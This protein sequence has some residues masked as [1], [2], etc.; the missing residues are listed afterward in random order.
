MPRK[1]VVL[2]ILIVMMFTIIACSN[3]KVAESNSKPRVIITSDGEIDDECSMVRCMLYANEWD[4]EAI[5][6]SSSQYHWHGHR[7]AGDDWIE[8]YLDAYEQVYHNLIKHDKDYPSPD[9]LR[10]RTALGN[11]KTE[12]EMDEITAGSELIVKVLLDDTDKRPIWLQAWGGPNTIARAL[13]T[14]EEEHPERMAEVANKIR[15]FMIWEQDS[16][17]QSYIRKNWGKYNIQ[18]IV[19]DQFEAIAYRWKR[20]QP[21]EMHPWYE[22]VWMTE[23]ILQNHGPLCSLYE[24]H[25]G[26][27]EGFIKGD[28]RS[29]GDSPA[30]MYQIDTGLRNTES[31]D[32]GGWAGR[33]VKIRENTWVDPVP[34]KGF[35]YPKGRWYGSSAW[36]RLSVKKGGSVQG[37]EAINLYFKPIWRWSKAFQNDFASRADWCIK[38]YDEANH[39]P[40]VKLAHGVD[41]QAMPGATINLNAQG[42]TDPD[43][44]DLSY[45]WWQYQEADTYDGNVEILNQ[46]KQEA[47][48]IVPKDIEKGETIHIICEVIDNGAPPL[49]RY[50]R[51]VVDV[52]P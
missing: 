30:F 9:Y 27:K 1:I 11:V 24:A 31:P 29:E 51:I 2:M 12:G 44:D 13:K 40:V 21:D 38:S 23:N 15:L 43:N 48:F 47:S 33:Y 17:Y 19:S 50:Q 4:I 5:V 41:L 46:D 28:F 14:I 26:E 18:A 34:V 45:H 8:P 6:T 10:E 42:T 36:G 20:C 49:T 39:P 37:S 35:E 16:T 25:R 32:W 7:W 22:S 52:K 3:V